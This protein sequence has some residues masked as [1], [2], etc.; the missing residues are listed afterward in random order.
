MTYFFCPNAPILEKK[1]GDWGLAN[2]SKKTITPLIGWFMYT[3]WKQLLSS[4]GQRVCNNVNRCSISIMM[5]E[6]KRLL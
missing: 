6:R 5:E 3:L 1:Q 4:Y 2:P